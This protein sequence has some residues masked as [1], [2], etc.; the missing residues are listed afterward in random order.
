MKAKTF[1]VGYNGKYIAKYK[2]VRAC[3]NFIDRKNLHNDSFNL[4]CIV[5]NLGNE[6]SLKNGELI[7][8]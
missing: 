4:L 2:S 5:D 3:L 6:Y 8:Y 7:A 1:W